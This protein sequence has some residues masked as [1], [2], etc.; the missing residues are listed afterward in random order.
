MFGP[1]AAK[2][3]VRGRVEVFVETDEAGENVYRFGPDKKWW[4]F[5][6]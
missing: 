2:K 6:K 3:A 5:W 4:Q 1:R